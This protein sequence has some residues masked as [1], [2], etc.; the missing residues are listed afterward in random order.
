MAPM[1]TLHVSLPEAQLRTDVHGQGPDVLLLHGWLSSGRMWHSLM[2]DLGSHYRLW[3]PDLAGFGDSPPVE[4]GTPPA[5]PDYVQ[6]M[7]DFCA[8]LTIRPYAVVGHSMGGLL[9]L[10]LALDHPDLV[11][12]LVLLSPAV[13]GKLWGK[14]DAVLT[15]GPGRWIM[16]TARRLWRQPLKVLMPSVFAFAPRYFVSAA[17]RRKAEDARK[18]TW[19]SAYGSLQAVL[20]SDCT[21]RLPEVRQPTLVIVGARDMTIPPSEGR[22]A[23]ERIPRARLVELPRVAHQVTDEAPDDVHR[24]L[25]AFLQAN[26]ATFFRE[27]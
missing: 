6:Q 7:V 15:S 8:A 13:S 12:R 5:L 23:A 4:A 9:A 25:L 16:Q 18:A 3:A 14:L 20:D 2:H 22:L 19:E 11:E 24:H 1:Q 27:D 10:T 26:G 17:A 21:A